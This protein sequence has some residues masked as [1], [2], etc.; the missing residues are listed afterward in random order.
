MFKSTY[1]EE[2]LQMTA[3]GD[4]FM[5]LIKINIIPTEF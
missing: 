2:H 1:S 3:S 4:V 5:K